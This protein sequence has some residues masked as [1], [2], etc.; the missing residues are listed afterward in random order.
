MSDKKSGVK[1]GKGS[2]WFAQV[3][4]GHWIVLVSLMIVV[5]MMIWPK[6]WPRNKLVKYR[7]GKR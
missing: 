3:P 7:R 1:M 4:T 2:D 5:V 6:R